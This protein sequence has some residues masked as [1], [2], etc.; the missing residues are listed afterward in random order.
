MKTQ[1]LLAILFAMLMVPLTLS[2]APRQLIFS[3]VVGP[4]TP[5][6]KMAL[7]FKS[8]VKEKLGD[9]YEVVIYDKASLMSDVEAVDAIAAGQI[10]FAAPALSKFVKHTSKLKVFDLP[11]MFPDMAAVSRFQNSF[12]GQMLL[13][14]MADQG[15]RGLGYLHN[16][17]K[18]L[19]A[20]R[21][22]E[23]PDDL[24][25]LRFRIINSDVLFD[26]FQIVNAK[27]VPIPW[28]ETYE[29]IKNDRVDGQENTW[30]N[31]YTSQFYKFQPYIME[32][33]HGLLDYMVITNQHF[34][35]SLD[36]HDRR[37][38]QY[39]LNMALEYG[40]AVAAAKSLNDRVDLRNMRGVTIIT[41]SPAEK[42]QWRDAMKPIWRKYETVIGKSI[43][44]AA[45]AASVNQ[46]AAQ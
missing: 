6:G 19:S 37:L 8:L 21:P 45:R 15:I 9:R 2:A 12:T 36:E 27:P 18:Q 22:F 32:S 16:G 40:N 44:E 28:P 46:V 25:G 11:F 38:M 39:S 5:K 3:H 17:L 43:V 30:S 24:A 34:W 33:N 26:Q 29:A 7:M 4:D 1:F 10:Q 14:S 41:P 23:T 13:N 42:L 35:A 20:N 31:I